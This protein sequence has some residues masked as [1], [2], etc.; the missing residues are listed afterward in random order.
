METIDKKL[1]TAI[2]KLQRKRNFFHGGGH[3][4]VRT[5]PEYLKMKQEIV[6]IT[7]ELGVP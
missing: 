4:M 1:K 7:R 3:I 5:E 2:R 6:D